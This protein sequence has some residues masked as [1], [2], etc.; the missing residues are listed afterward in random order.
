MEARDPLPPRRL[1]RG[2]TRHPLHTLTGGLNHKVLE[3]AQRNIIPVSVAKSLAGAKNLAEVIEL[4]AAYWRRQFGALAAQANAPSAC[5][6][7][8]D[9]IQGNF[10]GRQ[11]EADFKGNPAP[12][13]GTHHT[14]SGL[15]DLA[16]R[17]R[18]MKMTY[19]IL[20]IEVAKVILPVGDGIS[21]VGTFVS[22]RIARKGG[23][24]LSHFL[25][26]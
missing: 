22:F 4:Q 16:R 8:A 12:L 14:L 23:D 9:H 11:I 2:D 7:L 21:Q 18:K 25:E 5:L 20:L 24:R 13:L 10:D 3:I 17:P 15:V 26:P 6:K 1:R 19:I